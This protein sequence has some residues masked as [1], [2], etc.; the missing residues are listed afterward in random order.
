MT[1]ANDI[2][3]NEITAREGQTFTTHKGK[4]F[5]FQIKRP[6]N[7]ETSGEIRIN[8]KAVVITRATL[9]LAY[10]GALE[11]QQKKGCVEK[12]GKL[13]A[14]GDIY[15]YPL[16]L[17]IGICSRQKGELVRDLAAE[18]AAQAASSAEQAAIAQKKAAAQAAAEPDPGMQK[19][20]PGQTRCCE[21][22]GYTTD[23][24]FM[25]CPKCGSP[26]V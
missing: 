2:L 6:K 13:G 10:H 17:D 24:D 4:E 18:A 22:C 14:Y 7:G 25:F 15:L 3:W 12:P 8:G 19:T 16:F 21:K 5:T 20:T 11:E 1:E 9:L 26:L 23:E